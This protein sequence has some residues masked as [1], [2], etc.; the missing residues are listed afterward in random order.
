MRLAIRAVIPA[1]AYVAI[2]AG[3]TD[4]SELSA[5]E[6]RVS[7]FVNRER[8]SK[9][10]KSLEWDQQ[11]ADA[12]RSHARRMALRRFFSHADPELGDL[13]ERL[14][15]AKIP[16][17]KAAENLFTEKG[18]EDPARQTIQGW[19]NSPGHRGNMLDKQITRAGTGAARAADG[20]VYVVQIYVLR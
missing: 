3:Q 13:F 14:E 8:T 11:L 12:A 5:I 19:M 20:S 2:L 10:L 18:Y 1:V 7:E 17:R 15:D 4:T 6:R 16:W 9:G